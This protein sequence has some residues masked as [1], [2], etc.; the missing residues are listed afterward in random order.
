MAFIVSIPAHYNYRQFS[1]QDEAAKEAEEAGEEYVEADEESEE[2]EE[3]EDDEAEEV[4]YVNEEDVPFD[5]V[6]SIASK[7]VLIFAE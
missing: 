2:E 7:H 4:E 6:R 3:D 5:E 1:S